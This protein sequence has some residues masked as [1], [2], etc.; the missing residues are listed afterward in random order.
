MI[1]F[2]KKKDQPEKSLLKKL[3]E[4]LSLSSNKISSGIAD[5]FTRKKLDSA[6]L[7]QLEE[8]LIAADLGPSTAAKLAAEISRSRFDEEVSTEEIKDALAAEIEKILLPAEKQLS[9]ANARPFVILMVGVNGTG[10]T[11]T[12]GKLARR[13][14]QEGKQVMLA[15]GD[16]FRAAAVNQLQLW[17]ERVHC[18]VVA[19]LVGADAAALAFEAVDRAIAEN[20]DILMI[21][22]AGRLQNK[23][24]LMAELEKIIRVIKKKLPNAPHATL[25]VLDATVGQNAH[26]QVEL[27]KRIV[28]I[29]GLI[30][31]KLDGTAKGGVLVSLVER[32]ILHVSVIY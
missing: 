23:T 20:A 28:N 18:P 13:F 26:S 9:P 29:T 3:S 22:T 15:A 19:G 10:K 14:K 12:I 21:D 27:F 24:H 6:T 25:L 32:F 8:L 4:G 16:T 2:W 7:A 31:T 1:S 17:G 11:T 30:V 5:I